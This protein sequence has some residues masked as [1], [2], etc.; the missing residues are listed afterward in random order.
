MCDRA[1]D[2]P[3]LEEHVLHL[4]HALAAIICGSRLLCSTEDAIH[5]RGFQEEK[6]YLGLFRM[7]SAGICAIFPRET[8]AG[9]EHHQ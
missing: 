7:Y 2:A 1:S 6:L 5:K 3:L 8:C 4:P 9:Q